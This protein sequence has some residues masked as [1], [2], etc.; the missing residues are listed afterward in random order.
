M[1]QHQNVIQREYYY[2]GTVTWKD[3]LGYASLTVFGHFAVYLFTVWAANG[4]LG[5]WRGTATYVV[6]QVLLTLP[7]VVIL[8]LAGMHFY[9]KKIV[10]PLYSL[11]DDPPARRKKTVSLLFFGEAVRFLLG[12]LPTPM[13][14]FGTVTSPV[15]MMLYTLV[16]LNPAGR[17][18]PVCLQGDIRFTDIL[19]FAV[20]YL[21]YFALHER[22]LQRMCKKRI[23]SH[24]RWLEG[25]MAE[26]EKEQNYR[27][28]KTSPKHPKEEESHENLL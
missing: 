22:I 6:F 1:T 19:V 13:T 27:P 20:I 5:M 24:I 8:P 12:L 3:R 2:Q 18:D 28:T 4:L 14:L 16:Y 7:T 17:F 15:T 25:M 26:Y 21:G 9:L 23:R 11:A 10:P